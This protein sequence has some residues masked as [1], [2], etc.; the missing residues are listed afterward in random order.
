MDVNRSKVVGKW[1]R[2]CKNPQTIKTRSSSGQKNGGKATFPTAQEKVSGSKQAGT[3]GG[4]RV[5][6]EKRKGTIKI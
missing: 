5:R 2:G 3:K 4:K 6:G 1:R